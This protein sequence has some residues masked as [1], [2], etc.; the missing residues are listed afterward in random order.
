M[1]GALRGEME[2][3]E[4]M[5]ERQKRFHCLFG[6]QLEGSRKPLRLNKS[7]LKL[8]FVA[9][10]ALVL[11]IVAAPAV[12]AGFMSKS[13]R[14]V[15]KLATLGRN[16]GRVLC[17]LKA[18]GE[19]L[20][21]HVEKNSKNLSDRRFFSS[22]V[23]SPDGAMAGVYTRYQRGADT[24]CKLQLRIEGHRFCT[25]DS[26]RL[27]RLI[28]RRLQSR[29]AMLHEPGFYDH[30][31]VL[32]HDHAKTILLGWHELGSSCPAEVEI[33]GALRE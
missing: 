27:Q 6:G 2:F 12:E 33:A 31:Y 21:I 19:V 7:A 8:V 28:G 11:F 17:D 23:R 4:K 9:L 3:R 22:A 10:A 16:E 14:L 5:N 32:F 26:A 25:A 30:G 18:I 13:D 1:R 29:L 20:S 15:L 24:V